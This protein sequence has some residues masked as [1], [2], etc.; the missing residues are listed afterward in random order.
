MSNINVPTTETGKRMLASV[1]PIY[2]KSYVAR[3]LFEVI[4][5]EM[6]EARKYIEEVRLQAHPKTATWGLFYWEMRYHIP[7]DESLPIEERRKKV[8]SK[9]W[10]FAPMNPARLEQYIKEATGRTAVITEYTSNYCIEIAIGGY[11]SNSEYDKINELVKKAK[12][13]HIAAKII[14]DLLT[15]P[16]NFY[17][18]M[19]VQTGDFIKLKRA[20]M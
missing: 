20:T 2:D 10:K 3:W 11:I 14:L 15:E 5:V 1:S 6:E 12:P 17:I 19:W 4:G 13:S 9:R 18:G 16:M 8:L 7:I